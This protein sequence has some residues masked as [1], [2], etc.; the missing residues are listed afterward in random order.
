VVKIARTLNRIYENIQNF[1]LSQVAGDKL[2]EKHAVIDR[3]AKTSNRLASVLESYRAEL[4]I[5]RSNWLKK[6]ALLPSLV[7]HF[8]EKC[9]GPIV[10]LGK[11]R[12]WKKSCLSYKL[13]EPNTLILLAWYFVSVLI[14]FFRF[15]FTPC[16]C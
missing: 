4:F 16:R 15:Y 5:L 13:P 7:K 8:Y 2:I 14:C 9:F 3:Y 11:K 1:E 6:S 12:L 10:K